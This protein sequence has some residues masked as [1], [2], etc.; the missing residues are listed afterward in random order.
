MAGLIARN[1]IKPLHGFKHF[2]H[3]LTRRFKTS[4]TKISTCFIQINSFR[5]VEVSESTFSFE[6]IHVEY[7]QADQLRK[8]LSSI[9]D[10]VERSPAIVEM[11]IEQGDN[12]EYV[13]CVHVW[14]SSWTPANNIVSKAEPLS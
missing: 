9:I 10:Q 13:H 5:K 12:Q 3:A 6:S 1:R 8:N 14:P 4:I 11:V 7:I 2:G